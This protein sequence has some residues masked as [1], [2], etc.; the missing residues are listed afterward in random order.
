MFKLLGIIAVIAGGI[1]LF[2]W[3]VGKVALR[4]PRPRELT[5][6]D[7]LKII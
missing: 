7:E 6:E 4:R 5:D 2:F 1:Y 3:I